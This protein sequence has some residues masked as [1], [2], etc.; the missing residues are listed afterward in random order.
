MPL[1]RKIPC[2]IRR[3]IT[4]SEDVY[5]LVLEPQKVLPR[6]RPG[7][8]LH[9]AI[10][11]YDPSAFWPESRVFSI[12]SS[13]SNK[14]SL[15]ISYA[16]KGSFTSRMAE[17][18][19]EGARVWIK[20][21]YGEFI[22]KSD[23]NVIMVAGGT[24]ITA[25]TAFIES[26]PSDNSNDIQLFYGAR[27]EDLLIYSDMI[28]RIARSSVGFSAHFYLENLPDQNELDG[29]I[30]N[31]GQLSI[32]EICRSLSSP[33]QYVYYLSGPPPMLKSFKDQLYSRGINKDSVRIDAWE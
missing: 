24:G 18:L 22:I 21:P 29:Q 10:D 13:S 26:L 23:Q 9:L 16:V 14:E 4:H 8:F 25:F 7:Q 6:F 32:D 5:T 15:I 12:A 20:L 11:A 28:S 1:T 27:N 19:Y 30:Y 2:V 33:E 17:N 31:P 3:I